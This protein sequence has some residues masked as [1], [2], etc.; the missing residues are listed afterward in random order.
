MASIDVKK[1]A[2]QVLDLLKQPLRA[3]VGVAD[4]AGQAVVDV[5]SKAKAQVTHDAAPEGSADVSDFAEKFAT[6]EIPHSRDEL[7]KLSD[8]A[9]VRRLLESY[10]KVAG[11]LYEYLTEHGDK[12][13]EKYRPQLEQLKTKAESVLA[14]TPFAPKE[15]TAAEAG[16]EVVDADIVADPVVKRTTP[17]K[18]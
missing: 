7:K 8:S 4:I 5:A 10:G 11:E 16:P 9:E 14:K 13:V 15:E 3:A 2:E 6:V 17:K 18:D 12:T 1:S